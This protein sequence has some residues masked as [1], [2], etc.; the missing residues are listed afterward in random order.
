MDPVQ[1]NRPSSGFYKELFAS[2]SDSSD[3]DCWSSAEEVA[4]DRFNQTAD[5]CIHILMHCVFSF[6]SLFWPKSSR[7]LPLTLLLQDTTRGG[8]SC[9]GGHQFTERG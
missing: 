6:I 5:I 4:Q 8:R 7:F 3:D 2:E 9:C 1:R